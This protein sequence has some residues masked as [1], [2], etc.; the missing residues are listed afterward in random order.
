MD[1]VIIGYTP[2]KG[3]RSQTFG[4][5]HIAEQTD[6]GLRYLG[7]VGTGFDDKLLHSIDAEIRKLKTIPKPIREKPLDEK[8]STWIEPKL[9]CEVQYAS[10]TKDG[11]LREPVFLR[12]REDM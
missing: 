2:G 5:L 10:F 12:M 6:K 11:M 8:S 9:V 3:D 7:K 4:A 1:V